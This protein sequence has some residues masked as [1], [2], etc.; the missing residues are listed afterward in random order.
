MAAQR[1]DHVQGLGGQ[2]LTLPSGKPIR[3]MSHGSGA[4]YQGG[5]TGRRT[6]G[7]YAPGTGPT[8]SAVGNLENLRNRS[9][10]Q[11]RND[12][13]AKSGINKLV[14]NIVGTGI[15][16]RSTA[17]DKAFQRIVQR[18]FKGWAPQSDPEGLLSFYGQQMQAV[19]TWLQGG[20]AFVRKRPRRPADGLTVPLQVQVMEAEMCPLHWNGYWGANTIRH[21]IEFDVIGRR[22]AYWF[23]KAHPGDAAWMSVDSHQ[24]TRVPADEVIHLFDPVRPGQIRGVP[25]MAQ[26]LLRMY[27]LDKYDDA[28]LLRQQIANLFAMFIQKQPDEDEGGPTNPVTGAAAEDKGDDI[29]SIGLEPG[30]V[31][32]LQEGEVPKFSAPPDAGSSYKD[33]LVQQLQ[34][35][36]VGFEEGY[37]VMTGDFSRINDRLAR[38]VLQ[39]FRRRVQQ[40]QHHIVIHQ[41]C[42]RVWEWWLPR[43]I[44]AGL[45]APG[46]ADTPER[47]QGVKWIPQAWP[48]MHPLQDVAAHKESRRAGF[49]TRADIVSESTGEDIDEVHEQLA[50][51]NAA[52]EE[53]G[54]VLDSDAKYTSGSG[55]TQ[56]RP[57]GST[58]LAPEE[59]QAE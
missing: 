5:G 17:E 27:D 35:V 36:G 32:E 16:P 1:S 12:P 55:V 8:S 20:E 52:A 7:W 26:V 23:Y 30:I 41:L 33:F 53:L 15:K 51:E 50:A 24:L 47:Y 29:P 43:A 54:L 40:W 25:H 4:P 2:S 39:E 11:Y 38:L 48:Y 3:R 18:W 14:S 22:A 19:N 9:R 49:K 46:Y 21:G 58:F 34:A 6:R 10:S 42:R 57:E 13:Y 28:T 31:Q 45:E 56:A 44:L 59:E 37:E